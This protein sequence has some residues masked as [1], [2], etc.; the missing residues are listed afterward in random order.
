M[1]YMIFSLALIVG[2]PLIAGATAFSK[3][4]KY[5][6]LIGMVVSFLFNSQFSIN[7]LS[8]EQYR[9]PVRGF[10]ITLADIIAAGLILGMLVRSGSK[11]VWKPRFTFLLLG[12]FIFAVLNVY[13][14]EYKTYGWFAIWQ[15]FR[16]GIMYWCITNF[17]AT[18]EYSL[19]SIRVLMTSY[20]LTGLI[21]GLFA[22]K[23]KYLDGIYRIYA[24]FDHSNTVPSFALFFLCALLVWLVSDVSLKRLP[25]LLSL[26]S[27][28]GMTFAILATGSRTG[29]V[30]AGG[31]IVAALIISNFRTRSMRIKSTTIFLIICIAL[32]GL[33]VI[34]TVVDRFLN[35]PKESEEARNEFEVAAI[36]MADDFTWGVGLNQYSQVL[37]VTEKYRKHISVMRYETQA[38]VAHHI[39]L[40]T[41]AEMG[42]RGMLYFILIIVAFTFPMIGYGLAW[43]SLEQRLLL[44]LVVGLT[45]VFAIGLFEWVIR[46]S[47]VLYQLV[48]AAG[49]GQSLITKVKRDK[50]LERKKYHE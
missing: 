50:A 38:G 15:L 8:M 36:M 3:K 39:Y 14:S 47:T 4:L 24:T 45:A 13:N 48:V 21:L 19:T 12:F 33:M 40:L 5:L 7:I 20:A 29:I 31:S 10:E 27:V 9:G 23:Q 28:L 22:V 25:Y 46:Q 42:Y 17:F 30:L 44:A 35:A 2:T 18:E 49:F 11:I 34:D 1:K 16:M 26:I 37:T 6:A 43:K 41:A 32:G